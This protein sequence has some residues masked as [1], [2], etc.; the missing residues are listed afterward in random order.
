MPTTPT[1]R[2]LLSFLLLSGLAASA[3]SS[4][5]QA[6]AP[7][8]PKPN[9]VFILADD[10]GYNDIEPFGASVVKTPSLSRLANEGMKFTQAYCGTSVCA[11]SRCILMTG[12]HAGH[13]YIRANRATPPEGQ[14]PLPAGT[15]TLPMRAMRPTSFRVMSTTMT[16]SARFLAERRSA[17][18]AARSA[19]APGSRGAVP[20]I[21]RHSMC[22]P[23]VRK[24]SSGDAE[25]IACVPRSTNPPQAPRCPASSIAITPDGSPRSGARSRKV[26]LI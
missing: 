22:V 4:F 19:V 9:I 7:P 10:L 2:Q 8:A 18:A 12:L 20:F 6:P 14:E 5:A 17:S 11:P 13:A 23:T 24:N 1:R 16:F 25:Q 15:F 26:K 3:A 21:G